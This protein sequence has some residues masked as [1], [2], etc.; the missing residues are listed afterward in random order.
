MQAG[1]PE[2][3][4]FKSSILSEPPT[5]VEKNNNVKWLFIELNK[6]GEILKTPTKEDRT[7]YATNSG[8]IQ[9]YYLDP[10]QLLS[11][12]STNTCV[13]FMKK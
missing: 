6:F 1:K 12:I 5:F 11:L 4:K 9:I 13:D 10:S 3:S 2:G 8:G 7:I